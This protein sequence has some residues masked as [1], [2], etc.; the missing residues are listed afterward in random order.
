MKAIQMVDLYHQYLNIKDEVDAAM[1]NVINSCSFIN[2]MDT[3]LFAKE[4]QEYLGVNHAIPCGNGTDA[5]QIAL[6]A[7]DLEAGDEIITTPFT[8]IATAEVIELLKLK[9]V[10]VDVCPNTYLMDLNEVE[11]KITNR[12]KV[13][14]PVHLFGQAV[15]MEELKSLASKHNLYVVED[16]AQAIG[17]K[18]KIGDQTKSACAIGDIGCTSFFP[19]KNLGCFG[20]GG[21]IFTNSNALA[22]KIRMIINHGSKVKYYHEVVGVNSRLDTIQAA[23]L[24]VKLR[25]LDEFINNRQKA[26]RIYDNNLAKIESIQVPARVN[27]SEHVFHQYTMVV[28]G[29]RDELR[30]YLADSDIPSMIYYPIPLHLQQAYAYLN[31]KEGDFPISESLSKNVLSLPMHTELEM[32][33]LQFICRSIEHFFNG[34]Y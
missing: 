1:N 5:L 26:A 23:I 33:Q 32:D 29:H 15:N 3:K 6:M 34:N 12:T 19:S 20:D 22:E 7:L 18:V 27:W 8:F 28:K 10:F 4:L 16:G 31:H 30:A 11:S 2:G 21:A 24:R 13:I 17:A 14:I 9:P 25:K